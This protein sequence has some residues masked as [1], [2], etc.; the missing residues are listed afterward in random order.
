[1]LNDIRYAGRFLARQRAFTLVAVVTV[2]LGVGA[3]TAIF[4]I[5]DSV[6]FRPLPYADSDRL[7]VLEPTKVSTVDVTAVRDRASGPDDIRRHGRPA[8]CQR[9]GG[10]GDSRPAGHSRGSHDCL[11]GRMTA[12][13]TSRSGPTG[14][15]R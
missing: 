1:M 9:P 7:F 12:G 13:P 4:S 14:D 2:A 11:E 3:N 5:A 8:V 15:H 10:G 6:L